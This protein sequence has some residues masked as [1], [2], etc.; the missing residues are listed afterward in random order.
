MQLGPQQISSA[1]NVSSVLTRG[2]DLPLYA[3]EVQ[4]GEGLPVLETHFAISVQFLHGTVNA[5]P[6]IFNSLDEI[7][8]FLRN[9]WD[10][11]VPPG[12][13]AYHVPNNFALIKENVPFHLLVKLGGD[14]KAGYAVRTRPF[15]LTAYPTC[16][17]NLRD[18]S[19]DLI[20]EPS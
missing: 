6:A 2:T 19:K 16:I 18:K 11:S 10:R 13:P 17:N 12:C 8:R 15:P 7:W 9:D 5:D 4:V 14:F 1:L 3:P 20:R